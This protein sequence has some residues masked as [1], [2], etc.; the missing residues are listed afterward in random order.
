[1][2]SVPAHLKQPAGA[3]AW[4]GTPISAAGL[5]SRKRL[6]CCVPPHTTR[7]SPEHRVLH[8][9]PPAALLGSAVVVL[10]AGSGGGWQ[11]EGGRQAGTV[12]GALCTDHQHSAQHVLVCTPAVTPAPSAHQAGTACRQQGQTWMPAGPGQ[13]PCICVGSC[14]RVAVFNEQGCHMRS[15]ATAAAASLA[16]TPQ[17]SW[18]CCLRP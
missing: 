12:V 6:R 13:A 17:W 8:W 11:Q 2:P 14:Q 9:S 18:W 3:E 1:M 4:P 10:P 7:L 15:L 16:C 5:F